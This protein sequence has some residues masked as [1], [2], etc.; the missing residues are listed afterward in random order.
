VLQAEIEEFKSKLNKME[1]TL[2]ERECDLTDRPTKSSFQALEDLIV[3][4]DEELALFKS[5]L[6]ETT[7]ERDEAVAKQIRLENRLIEDE[8]S[9]S[10]S[11]KKESDDALRELARKAEGL[12]SQ[13]EDLKTER[14]N[15]AAALAAMKESSRILAK[16]SA[17][18]KLESEVIIKQRTGEC[19]I[20]SC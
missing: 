1:S 12:E 13:V 10:E 15:S 20:M 16:E 6:E 8:L 3:A 2:A 11:E 7:K 17:E 19:P 5:Q 14:D 4:K 9:T 18:A